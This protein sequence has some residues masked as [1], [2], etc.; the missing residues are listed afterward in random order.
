M[1]PYS[2]T[3]LIRVLYIFSFTILGIIRLHLTKVFKVGATF[4][5][6]SNM[7]LPGEFLGE[8]HTKVAVC[9]HTLYFSSIELE[10]GIIDPCWFP[11]TKLIVLIWQDYI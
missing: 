10:L 8:Y 5:T 3:G 11:G 2:R 6:V 9:F 4:K 7:T 1:H